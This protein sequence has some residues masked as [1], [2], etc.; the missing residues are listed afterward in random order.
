MYVHVCI[1]SDFNRS[2]GRL[3][4]LKLIYTS[5]P[6]RL[7]S[8]RNYNTLRPS[9]GVWWEPTNEQ[10]DDVGDSCANTVTVTGDT[11]QRNCINT[12]RNWPTMLRQY[13]VIL[14][15]STAQVPGDTGRRCWG[16]SACSVTPARASSTC[17]V[18]H[19]SSPVNQT[20]ITIIYTSSVMLGAQTT[21]HAC[22]CQPITG[23]QKTLD[24]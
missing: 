4:K 1:Y 13:L 18:R 22:Q 3:T 2:F 20:N 10:L 23:I 11:D 7:D 6:L 8:S 24:V 17:C 5:L 16:V 9:T 14:T 15:K 21:A 19:R 12:C